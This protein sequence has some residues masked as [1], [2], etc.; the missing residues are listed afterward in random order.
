[1]EVEVFV[2]DAAEFNPHPAAMA[3]VGRPEEGVGV[4]LDED[5]LE[6][7]RDGQP[8]GDTAVVVV[9]VGKH[10]EHFLV[11][12][13]GRFAVRQAFAGFGEGEAEAA[14]SFQV[15]GRELRGT[16]GNLRGKNGRD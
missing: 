10:H 4:V 1:M 12:E 11:D 2:V 9:V 13:K 6:A 5:G 7:G 14:D 3:D 16:H 15:G 8:D